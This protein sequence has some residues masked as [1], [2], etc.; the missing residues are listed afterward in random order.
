MLLLLGMWSLP[1]LSEGLFRNVSQSGTACC[2]C[3]QWHWLGTVLLSIWITHFQRAVHPKQ[4]RV[5]NAAS[6]TIWWQGG[7]GIPS[8]HL[9]LRLTA[10]LKT[11]R[12]FTSPDFLHGICADG[13]LPP[14]MMFL[15]NG[16]WKGGQG[17]GSHPACFSHKALLWP[18][19][20][21]GCLLD[22][23]LDQC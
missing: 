11:L 6:G 8:I 19:S 5:F 2:C 22:V 18:T 3:R 4:R 9:L 14:V 16:V 21:H 20:H 13:L 1:R 23:V 7:V 15:V 10:S 17:Q 12:L